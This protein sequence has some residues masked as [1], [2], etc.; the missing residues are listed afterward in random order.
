MVPY[1]A[2]VEAGDVVCWVKPKG[3]THTAAWVETSERTNLLLAC[4]E[5]GTSMTRGSS[6][7]RVWPNC[8]SRI[9]PRPNSP[10]TTNF[11]RRSFAMECAGR[12]MKSL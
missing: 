12:L 10:P 11:W 6:F 7:W 4:R 9:L 3:E 5:V 8:Y 1:I 2:C